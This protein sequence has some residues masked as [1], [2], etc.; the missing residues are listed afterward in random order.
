MYEDAPLILLEYIN[1]NKDNLLVKELVQFLN[2]LYPEAKFK[3]EL[4]RLFRMG[5]PREIFEDSVHKLL[6]Q[7]VAVTAEGM[8]IRY[9][10]FFKAYTLKILVAKFGMGNFVEIRKW[11]TGKSKQQ[12][13]NRLQKYLKRQSLEHLHGLRINLEQVRWNNLKAGKSFMRIKKSPSERL[14][15]LKRYFTV[16]R[17]A[18]QHEVSMRRKF[19]MK[20]VVYDVFSIEGLKKFYKE[21]SQV[22]ADGGTWGS[23]P[24]YNGDLVEFRQQI[25]WCIKNNG[26]HLYDVLES[27]NELKVIVKNELEGS[28]VFIKGYQLKWAKTI[29]LCMR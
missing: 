3:A 27:F 6:S 1:N 16:W 5:Q 29:I 21:V 20:F 12:I 9:S 10:S 15:Q 26:K 18:K 7:K 17:Y 22:I 4:N 23:Y 25:K 8:M 24:E 11:L 19:K 2:L 28:E 13:Y 14:K